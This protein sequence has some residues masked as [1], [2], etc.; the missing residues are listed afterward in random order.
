VI[1][2]YR[3]DQHASKIR[4]LKTNQFFVEWETSFEYTL[5]TLKRR[6]AVSERRQPVRRR[7]KPRFGG[8]SS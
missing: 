5:K 2:C 6:R 3:A 1:R 8:Y 7:G 4:P